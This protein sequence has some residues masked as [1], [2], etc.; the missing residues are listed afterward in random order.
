MSG[1][2]IVVADGFYGSCGKGHVTQMLLDGDKTE[3]QVNVRVG[4]PNAGHIV[5]GP[6]CP[7]WCG[8]GP[9]HPG[10][11]MPWGDEPDEDHLVVDG[12]RYHPWKLRQ[13]PV[14][15][16]VS[17]G[18]KLV[19]AAGSEINEETLREE[20]RALESAGYEIGQR[21][22]ID[23][24]ATVLTPRH[25]EQ[26][27]H[28]DLT[29]KLGSTAKGIGAARADRIWRSAKTWGDL[30]SEFGYCVDTAGLIYNW[31]NRGAMVIIEGTQGYGL[32]LHTENYPQVTSTDCRAIDFLAQAGLSPWHKTVREFEPWVVLRTRPIRVAGNSGPMKGETTWEEIGLRPEKTT[33]TKKVRRVGE[34]D[35]ALANRAIDANGG[36]GAVKVA[37]TMVD[38]VIP[39]LFG[40]DFLEDL[41]PRVRER[42]DI[43][44]KEMEQKLDGQTISWVGTG[45]DTGLWLD[46]AR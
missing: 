22:L 32:G 23:S 17:H 41:D 25:I 15:A 10:M 39:E 40:V 9:D 38:Q 8:A 27:K 2:L 3:M 42:L 24:S 20:V 36:H 14:G 44:V 16:V 4:G 43:F 30:N 18:C 33:V 46:T 37:L 34:F 1:K 11:E 13:I 26:E 6:Q 21:L 7:A 12:Y 28:H 35:A 45:P 19:I 31:L 29:A 5:Y